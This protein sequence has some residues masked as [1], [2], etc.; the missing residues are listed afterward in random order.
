MKV[1]VSLKVKAFTKILCRKDVEMIVLIL[2]NTSYILFFSSYQ[3]NQI[4]S[5]YV[6]V[7][8]F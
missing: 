3:Y 5:S 7:L 6:V 4:L 8:A 2:I 1:K